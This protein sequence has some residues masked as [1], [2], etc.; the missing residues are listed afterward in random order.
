MGL[1]YRFGESD[2]PTLRGLAATMKDDRN[3]FK[4]LIEAIE[5]NGQVNVWYEY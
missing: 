1:P 2:I 4:E 3:P 5:K